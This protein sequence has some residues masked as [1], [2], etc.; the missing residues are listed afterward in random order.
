MFTGGVEGGVGG[1]SLGV[2]FTGG[3]FVHEEWKGRGTKQK[4]RGAS[5]A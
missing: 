5:V 2:L 3:P 4:Q 1:S